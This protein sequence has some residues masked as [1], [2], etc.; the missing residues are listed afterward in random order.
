[1][2]EKKMA[3]KKI[4]YGHWLAGLTLCVMVIA[5]C[6]AKNQGENQL[7]GTT[8]EGGDMW[9]NS[10]TIDFGISSFKESSTFFSQ[11][12]EYKISGE[13]V[14]L[15]YSNGETLTPGFKL[16]VQHPPGQQKPRTGYEIANTSMVYC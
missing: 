2:K 12:G 8:W 16:Q 3:H 13:N 1:M 4:R 15:K 10:I 11:T 9:R 7:N 6:Q 5:G 14:T